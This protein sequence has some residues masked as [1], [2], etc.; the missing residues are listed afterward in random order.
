MKDNPEKALQELA[1]T[2]DPSGCQEQAQSS[3]GPTE[4]TPEAAEES[5]PN[6]PP[7]SMLYVGHILDEGDAEAVRSLCQ[8]YLASGEQKPLGQGFTNLLAAVSGKNSS[9]E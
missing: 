9:G 1:G 7:G 8:Q 6:S 2:K 5:L 3:A 4:A